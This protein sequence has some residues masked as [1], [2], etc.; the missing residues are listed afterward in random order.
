M[1]ALRNKDLYKKK[2]HYQNILDKQQHTN[3]ASGMK[4]HNSRVL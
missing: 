1:F 3:L 4:A 2:I